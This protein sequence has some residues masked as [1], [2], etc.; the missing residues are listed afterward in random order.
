[1]Q[2]RVDMV[3]GGMAVAYL[4]AML[5]LEEKIVFGVLA[6]GYLLLAAKHRKRKS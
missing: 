1:M 4:F 2:S 5:G 3:Y 6:I